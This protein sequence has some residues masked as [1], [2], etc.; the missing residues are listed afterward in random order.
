ML[1]AAMLLHGRLQRVQRLNYY[2]NIRCATYLAIWPITWSRESPDSRL[3]SIQSRAELRRVAMT[4]HP[5]C[6]SCRRP[7]AE[8]AVSASAY[9]PKQVPPELD[10]R[11][12]RHP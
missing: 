4:H 10:I 1:R 3:T 9:R 11:V 8:A 12:N 5:G 7:A 6:V 2:P